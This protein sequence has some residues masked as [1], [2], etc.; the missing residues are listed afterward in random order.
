MEELDNKIKEL[1]EERETVKA[2][3]KVLSKVGANENEKNV[4]EKWYDENPN[5][6]LYKNYPEDQLRNKLDNLDKEIIEKEKQKNQQTQQG[7]SSVN[8]N[9]WLKDRKIEVNENVK[10]RMMQRFGVGVDLA[11]RTN[12]K[13][14]LADYYYTAN[15]LPNTQ[16]ENELSVKGYVFNGTLYN[17][18][19]SLVICFKGCTPH[20]LKVC[21]NIEY[22]RMK[23]WKTTINNNQSA[24]IIPFALEY[25]RNKYY[26][27]MP[28]C[29]TT[30]EH[31]PKLNQDSIKKL[32]TQLKDAL[33]C[34]HGH[35]YCHMDIKPANILVT[36]YGDF[37]LADLGSLVP[38][39]QQTSS[40]R[41]YLP[42]ELWN[43]IDNRPPR[44]S[45]EVDWWMVAM[46]L[47]EKAC[48]GVIGGN[49]EPSKRQVIDTLRGDNTGS[50]L[51][52]DVLEELL[53]KLNYENIHK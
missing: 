17:G 50:S 34:F 30:L 37:Y 5:H 45:F 2:L 16:T 35:N 42:R 48:G 22:D 8:I 51:P 49:V 31:M 13:D 1:E 19:D 47:Y 33:E 4:R 7:T 10:K 3:L 36:M 29:P 53:Q 6:S 52:N 11:I 32:W 15:A 21:S 23:S 26:C 43:I 14:L 9:E 41:A 27:I 39:D 24:Y 25:E 40:T 46:T 18:N 44:S 12:D 28:L 20:I 38:K